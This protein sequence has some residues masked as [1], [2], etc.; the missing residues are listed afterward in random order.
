LELKTTTVE[1]EKARAKRILKI[2]RESV[3][4]QDK[5]FATLMVAKE[6]ADPFRTLVVTILSQNCTDKAALRAYRTLDRKIGVTPE[7]LSHTTTARIIRAIHEAGLHRQKARALRRLAQIIHGQH[8]S[9]LNDILRCSLDEARSFL[10]QLPHVGPKTADVL[11]SVWGQS[12]ISVDTHVNRVSKRLGLAPQK[13][14]YEEVRTALMRLY[15]PE[16]YRSIPLLFMA[17]GRSICKA[18]RPRCSICPIERL[19]PYTKKTKT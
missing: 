2:L 10:Q 6:S 14:K 5:D 7:N 3:S 8:S 15:E 17:H 4:I 11:L 16:D 13:A 12:T 1:P 18:L 19:C 9:A